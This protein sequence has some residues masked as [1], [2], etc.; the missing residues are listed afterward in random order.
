[1][2]RWIAILVTAMLAILQT[3]AFAECD[4]EILNYTRY[5]SNSWAYTRLGHI[6][7]KTS[8][9][10]RMLLSNGDVTITLSMK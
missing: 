9:E 6:T 4:D 7:D 3:G 8:D 2:K 10:I 1:M 5:G